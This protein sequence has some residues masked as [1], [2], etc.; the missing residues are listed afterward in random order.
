MPPTSTSKQPLGLKP[1]FAVSRSVLEKLAYIEQFE[2]GRDREGRAAKLLGSAPAALEF[3]RFLALPLLYPGRQEYSF[4][5]SLR[6]DLLWHTFLLDTPRYREFC[7]N[8]Y[9]QYLDHV[10][11]KSRIATK[12]AIREGPMQ[13]TVASIMGAFDGV[14][15]RFWS[16]IAFC[17][18][19]LIFNE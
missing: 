18:P 9:G 15:K 12:R 17:G 1:G 6:L 16:D 13:F 2:L 10:P 8:V 19:C 5:P 11:G 7:E 14:N 3:K 4:V